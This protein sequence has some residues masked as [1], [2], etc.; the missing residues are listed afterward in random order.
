MSRRSIRAGARPAQ[1]RRKLERL[2][3][4][5]LV[6]PHVRLPHVELPKDREEIKRLANEC[7]LCREQGHKH[8]ACP[9]VQCH[10]CGEFGHMKR[11]CPQRAK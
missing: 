4:L 9:T 7:W 1:T 8:T 3:G 2:I 10:A 5:G 11:R 6:P